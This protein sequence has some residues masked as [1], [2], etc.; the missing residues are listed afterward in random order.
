MA[1]FDYRQ[2]VLHAEDV[3]LEEIA[4]VHATPAYVYSRTRIEERYTAFEA[5]LGDMP[6]GIRYAVKA[7][8]NLAVLNVLAQLGSGFDIVSGGELE[9]VIAAGGDTTKVVFSGVG[10]RDDELRFAL[11]RDIEC[12]NVESP[13]ELYRLSALA[14]ELE[15]IA[16]VALRVNPDVDPQTHPHI[17]TGLRENKFGIDLTSALATYRQAAKL[18]CLEIRGIGCHIGSQLT[19]LAPFAEALDA[20]MPLVDQLAADGVALDH[21]DVGGG[22]AIRYR[23]EAVP[24]LD[25]YGEVIRRAL[26]GRPL[27]VLIEPGRALVGEA[28]VLLTRVLYT[29]ENLGKRFAVV[30][31]AMNDLLRPALY[32][33]WHEVLPVRPRAGEG[34]IYDVVGPVCESADFLAKTRRL[35]LES[36][37]LLAMANAGAYGFTMSSNYNSRSRAAEVMV[38]RE[39]SFEIR[40]R[41]TLDDQL[42]LESLPPQ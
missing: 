42:A 22:F 35:N 9:R 40:R 4:R 12:F 10:K 14:E 38:H 19:E 36:G 2:D 11:G 33:G 25:Q 31:A 21:I 20:L 32:D 24:E 41:E 26:C 1:I 18:P 29:K 28:G 27:T 15:A 30:D 13:Q 16:R 17:S 34:E 8:S 23:D 39:R 5:A 37:D 6:H 3:S 7:N